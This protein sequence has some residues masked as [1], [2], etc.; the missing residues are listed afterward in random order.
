M[1][2]EEKR[3]IQKFLKEAEKALPPICT[4]EEIAGLGLLT[5]N[6][7]KRLRYDQDCC[8]YIKAKGRIKYLR[9]DVLSWIESLYCTTAE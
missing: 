3:V 8:P 2:N 7:L 6:Q 5:I 9:S 1:K 4:E